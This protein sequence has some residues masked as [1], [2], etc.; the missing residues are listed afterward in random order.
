MINL[1]DGIE[2]LKYGNCDV[3][4]TIDDNTKQIKNVNMIFHASMKYQGY[5]AETDYNVEYRF[6]AP[7]IVRK[8]IK[9]ELVDAYGPIFLEYQQAINTYDESNTVQFANQFPDVREVLVKNNKYNGIEIW[10]GFYDIDINGMEELIFAY[11]D[12]ET[13][14]SY[15]I[16]DIFTYSM[17]EIEIRNI[18]RNVILSEDI[19]SDKYKSVIYE[20]GMFRIST[21]DK[22]EFYTIGDGEHTLELVKKYN[23]VGNYP[24]IFY[25]NA[26]EKFG[27]EEFTQILNREGN[28][29]D[30][31]WEKLSE[32]IVF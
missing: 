11:K 3:T 30:I 23:V 13:D 31:K 27:E 1:L 24:N 17:D 6:E 29:A 2:D 7:K 16:T 8:E 5:N 15:K 19:V 18:G 25:F 28:S 26:E 32:V 12:T 22:E 14:D 4:V 21:S 20:S 9:G 10:Y